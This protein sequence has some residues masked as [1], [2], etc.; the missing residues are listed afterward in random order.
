[1][2]SKVPLS[3]LRAR[4]KRFQPPP[5]DEVHPEWEIAIIF[6]KINLYYFSETIRDGMLRI[7]RGK[8]ACFWVRKS[9]EKQLLSP[10]S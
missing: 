5:M 8:E 4:M 6:S 1:M 2:N 9:L 3:E 10:F 7:P